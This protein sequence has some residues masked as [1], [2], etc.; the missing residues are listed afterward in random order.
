MIA[1]THLNKQDITAATKVAA[2]MLKDYP[3]DALVDV[4]LGGI[5]LANGDRSKARSSFDAALKKDPKNLKAM[6]NLARLDFEDGL[7][8]EAERRYN[9]ILLQDDK[10]LQA[11]IGVAQIVERQGKVKDAIEWVKR[12]NTANPQA[13]APVLVL[14]R[15]YLGQKDYAQADQVIT[16][17]LQAS[18]NHPELTKVRA[19]IMLVQG[20]H[21]E[22]LALLEKLI[23]VQPNDASLYRDLAKIQ[24]KLGYSERARQ[25]LV[26]GIRDAQQKTPLTIQLIEQEIGADHLD[27]AMREIEQLKK[28]AE[29]LALAL[30]LEGDVRMKQAR[31]EQAAAAYTKALETNQSYV[32]LAKLMMAKHQ[33]GQLNQIESRVREWLDKHNRDIQGRVAIAQV[34]L[35]LGK[36]RRAIEVYEA[37]Q[38]QEPNNIAVL[39]NL[40]WV[41]SLEQDPRGIAVARKAHELSPRSAAVKD[42]LGW[43]LVNNQQIEEGTILLRQAS[44]LSPVNS[45]I[46]LHLVSALQMS[47]ANAVEAKKLLGELVSAHP[48]LKERADVNRILSDLGM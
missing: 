33:L 12:A 18:P 7:L 42:T 39:N 35:Q 28:S 46:T 5:E 29:N 25:T 37:L 41:Y 26:K 22:S 3:D 1:L 2:A 43:L 13:L 14:S 34:Y 19:S 20:K 16:A 47:G 6:I 15:Y 4:L 30:G 38:A 8:G 27:G 44:E 48:E 36:N 31:Y 10:N 45:E 32:L 21:E 17:G 23:A 40:A 11:L 9:E 24:N